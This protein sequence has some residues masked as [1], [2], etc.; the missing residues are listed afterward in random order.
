MTRRGK[1]ILKKFAEHFGSTDGIK[2]SRAPGRVNL[3]GEH[4]DYNEGFVLPIA[5]DRDMIAGFRPNGSKMVNLYAVE[6]NEGASFSLVDPKTDPAQPWMSYAVGV[7]RVLTE[8]GHELNGIDA[9][10][11]ST[12]PVG[13]GLSSS[14]AFLV[15]IAMAYCNAAGIS[16]ERKALARMCQQA[17][18]RYA[19]ANVG[20]MDQ[21]T[22]LFG[23]RDACIFLDCRSIEHETVPFTTDVVKV[24][25]AD[26]T[27][28]HEIAAGE[29]NKRRATCEKGVE[30]LKQHLPAIKSLRDVTPE[31]IT[32]LAS[33]LPEVVRKR[34]RHVVTENMRVQLAVEALKHHNFIQFGVYMEAS[35]ESLSRDYEV[36]CREL[37]V[38][39]EIALG[40]KGTY[41][42]RMTGGG[43]GGCTVS[44]VPAENADEFCKQLAA[45]YEE[46]TSLKPNVYVC[47][48]APSAEIIPDCGAAFPGC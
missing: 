35:H 7:A 29:Y 43:F 46:R 19:G 41:G 23:E 22:A 34:V 26:T 44:L 14:A 24:V 9:V 10:L 8:H 3:I 12:V 28:R 20:I 39:V 30:L 13:S 31:D 1:N 40:L 17:E 21:Y 47:A 5:I 48:T 2:F 42:S 32:D 16:I 37:D 45:Q 38:M 15:S 4:T 25:V 27:I 6:M 33:S 11:Q 36:S 18:I